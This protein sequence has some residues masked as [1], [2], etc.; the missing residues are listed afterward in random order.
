MSL[1]IRE[2][3]LDNDEAH[4]TEYRNYVNVEVSQDG[5]AAYILSS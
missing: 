3:D 5:E 4:R 1:E 2:A